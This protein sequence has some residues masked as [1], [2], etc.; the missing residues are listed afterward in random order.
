MKRLW[1]YWLAF[2]LCAIALTLNAWAAQDDDFTPS[3]ALIAQMDELEAATTRLRGLPGLSPVTRLFPTRDDVRAFLATE[4]D[5]PGVTGFYD[6]AAQ[7][8]IAFGFLP[9]GTDLLALLTDFLEDQIGGF[10]DPEADE[11]NTVLLTGERPG[12]RLPVTEQI[13]FVHEYVHALQDQ[14]FDLLNLLETYETSALGFNTDRG[15][16]IIALYE[17]DATAVMTDYTLELAEEDPLGVLVQILAQGAASGT[18]VIPPTIPDIIENELLSPYLDGVNFV[19][20][21]RAEGGWAL[22]DRAYEVL[23]RSTEQILHPEK[24]LAGEAPRFVYLR[25]GSSEGD[26]G[27]GSNPLGEGW[28]LL[29]DR[30][31][32]EWYL[33]QFLRTQLPAIRANPAAAGWGGDRYHLFYNAEADQHAYVLRLVWDTPEDAAEFKGALLEYGEARFGAPAGAFGCWESEAGALCIIDEF[34]DDAPSGHV[35]IDAPDLDTVEAL[36]QYYL[37]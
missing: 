26:G 5:D 23:P 10:Y 4:L 21:L 33:R 35:L 2:S 27:D 11:L 19:E 3:P 30:T 25:P 8:Y 16:A 14:H 15:Q 7:F 34:D 24:Y 13:V 36:R 20:A 9:A 17:G 18:L 6:D 31:L 32:G 37:P 28:T 12:D 1:K 22:V 29:F